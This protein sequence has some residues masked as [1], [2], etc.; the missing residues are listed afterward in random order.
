MTD[1]PTA[2]REEWLEARTALLEREKE[3]T[4]LSD[5]VARERQALPLVR[6]DKEYVF[7]TVDG[8]K[9]LAELFDGRSQLLVYHFMLD[10][11]TEPGCPSCSSIADGVN[12]PHVHLENHDVA[13]VMVSRAPLEKIQEYRKRMGWSFRWVSSHDNDFNFDFGVSSTEERPLREYNFAPVPEGTAHGEY[14][15]L[16]AF[17][18]EGGAVFHTYSAYSRGVDAIWGVYQWLDR[19]PKGRNEDGYWHRRRDEYEAASA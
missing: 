9:T 8:P 13:F 2:T 6:I 17:A 5:E 19:A 3:L 10:A 11:D 7:D 16:S 14:P 15:G 12:G 4:R 18:I 1:H